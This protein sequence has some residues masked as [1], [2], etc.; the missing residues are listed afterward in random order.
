[1]NKY[2]SILLLI[3]TAAMTHAQENSVVI[4]ARGSYLLPVGALGDRFLG[5]YGGAL[6]IAPVQESPVWSASVE[7]LKFSKG[8][9]DKFFVTRPIRRDSVS[10][11][12]DTV[13]G[14]INGLK[15]SLEVFGAAAN[16]TYDIWLTSWSTLKVGAGFGFYYWKGTRSA[17]T[18]TI[19]G[20]ASWGPVIVA[21]PKVPELKQEDWSGGFNAGADLNILIA[22]PLSLQLGAR[23]KLIV[24]ELW[25]T[26]ALDLENVSTFQML[27]LRAG[28]SI[29]L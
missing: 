26:L 15:T 23:Y 25:P 2:L 4:T 7:Y 3:V 27:D 24:G 8:N 12:R 18:D 29:G 10:Q 28:I 21:T 6:D 11:Q 9:D 13:Q 14:K 20:T 17:F 22:P 19:R 16:I 5:G 1:M